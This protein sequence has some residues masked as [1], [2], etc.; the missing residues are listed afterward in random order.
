MKGTYANK[1]AAEMPA[2]KAAST[3]SQTAGPQQKNL[4]QGIDDLW[5]AFQLKEAQAKVL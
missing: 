1:T 5:G 3:K 4:D 2:P